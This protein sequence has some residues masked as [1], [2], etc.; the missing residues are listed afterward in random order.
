MARARSCQRHGLARPAQIAQ[1]RGEV[2]QADGDV[3]VVGAVGGLGDGQRPFEQRHGVAAAAQIL[4]K[5]AAR[6][7]SRMATVGWSGP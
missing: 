3:G 7:L 5:L 6:L 4:Q 1:A 2:A